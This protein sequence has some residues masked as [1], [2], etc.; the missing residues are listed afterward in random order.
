MSGL[1]ADALKGLSWGHVTRL[2]HCGIDTD[3]ITDRKPKFLEF[4]EKLRGINVCGCSKRETVGN[5]ARTLGWIGQPLWRA[6]RDL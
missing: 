2:P 1:I 5:A 6:L 3:Q 4:C